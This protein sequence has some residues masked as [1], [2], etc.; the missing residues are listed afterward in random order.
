MQNCKQNT[1]VKSFISSPSK[2]ANKTNSATKE[3]SITIIET[4]YMTEKKAD[5]KS[6]KPISNN[7]AKSPKSSIN[8]ENT[9]SPKSLSS[10]AKS[11]KQTN[12][13]TPN[14]IETKSPN[15]NDAKSP[16]SE[17]SKS[18]NK[19]IAEQKSLKSPQAKSK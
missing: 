12:N 11:P 8:N 2:S 6:P 16:K 13:L 3:L 10:D 1:N 17:G 15:N 14:K 9:K 4:N 5:T 7:D 18:P 19:P